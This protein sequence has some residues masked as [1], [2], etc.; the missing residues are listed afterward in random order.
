MHKVIKKFLF[1]RDFKGFSG[2]HL[3]VWHYFNHFN[4]HGNY[5][6]YISFS[7]D[8]LWNASNPWFSV[9]NRIL[10]SADEIKS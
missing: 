1:F 4:T 2:G 9:K 6:P 3:K 5:K 10:S 8:S 7:E